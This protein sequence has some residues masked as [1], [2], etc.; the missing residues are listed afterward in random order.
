MSTGKAIP[1]QMISDESKEPQE[2][3]L[4]QIRKSL[5]VSSLSHTFENFRMLKGTAD[6]YKL[7]RELSVPDTAWR[8]LLCYGGVGNGK[9]YLLEALSIALYKQGR[10]ARI[11]TMSEIMRN[12]RKAMDKT[13][14]LTPE[15]VLDRYCTAERLLI[16]DVGMGGSGSDWEW[17]QFEE[18][19]VARYRARLLTAVTTNLDLKK[20][21]D[22]YP[23]IVSRF[24]DPEIGRIVLNEGID[25]RARKL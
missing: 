19:I 3:R 22:D 14:P 10:K 5:N 6:S 17:G 21:H 20:L 25:Y 15:V 18:I 12:L 24:R 11:V 16:D 9:T 7:F 13:N 1:A 23:R 4:E 2:D 8:M